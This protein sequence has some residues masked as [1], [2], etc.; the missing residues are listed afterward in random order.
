MKSRI[1]RIYDVNIRR[2][3][4]LTLPTWLRRPLVGALVYAGVSPLGRLVG[5]L[6][7]FRRRTGYRMCHN[8]QVCR[9]RGALNDEFDP[10]QRRIGIEDCG[11]EPGRVV[12]RRALGRWVIVPRRGRGA[13]AVIVRAGFGGTGG[14]D[15]RVTVPAALRPAVAEARLRAVVN[16]YKLA[17]KRCAVIYK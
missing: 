4:L 10:E 6:R 1:D 3:A 2:L 11:E 15:F 14:Y 5:E 8:G 7:G 16:L 17:G 13:A 12:R 9:L